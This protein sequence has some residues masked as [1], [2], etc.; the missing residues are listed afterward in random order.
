MQNIMSEL[1]STIT[2]EICNAHIH[3]NHGVMQQENIVGNEFIVDVSAS[4]P[5]QGATI[6]DFIDATVSYADIYDIVETQMAVQSDILEHVAGRIAQN[7]LDQFPIIN[8][9][10][11]RIEK[12]A[13]PISGLDGS[14]AASIHL[15]R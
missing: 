1:S 7:I 2:V 4:Y 5:I 13:P 3:A 12:V 15:H 8:D 14:A 11:V 6:E 10:K 9:I